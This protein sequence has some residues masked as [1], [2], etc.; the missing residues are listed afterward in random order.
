MKI[1]RS[2]A[3]LNTLMTDDFPS[4]ETVI[5]YALPN[6]ETYK[7]TQSISLPVNAHLKGINL[8]KIEWIADV[9]SGTTQ[10]ISILGT[11]NSVGNTNDNVVVDGLHLIGKNVTGILDGIKMNWNG[12]SF[13]TISIDR[14]STTIGNTSQGTTIKNCIIENMSNGLRIENSSYCKILRNKIRDC[15]VSACVVNLLK[16]SIFSNNVIERIAGAQTLYFYLIGR[17]VIK[18]NIIQNNLGY[19]EFQQSNTN[20]I[21]GNS[22]SNNNGGMIIGS[23]QNNTICNNHIVNCGSN[24]QGAIVLDRGS[25]RSVVYGNVISNCSGDGITITSYC[26]RTVM[27]GNIIQ[28]NNGVGMRLLADAMSPNRYTCIYDNIINKNN[29]GNQ[30]IASATGNANNINMTTNI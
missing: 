19:I 29:G 27:V 16:L 14:Q 24:T 25:W 4:D 10:M 15:R 17:S 22:I 11:A 28:Y 20:V 3:D 30:S 21:A 13:D 26:E 6:D 2:Q 7:I 12:Y 23:S 1:I 9:P 18:D 5:I 8:P